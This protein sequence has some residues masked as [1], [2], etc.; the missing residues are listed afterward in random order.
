MWL[1]LKKTVR[2]GYP[3]SKGLLPESLLIVTDAVVASVGADC[4]SAAALPF[5]AANKIQTMQTF[6]GRVNP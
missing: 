6:P 3:S 2:F 5:R 1:Q 4:T